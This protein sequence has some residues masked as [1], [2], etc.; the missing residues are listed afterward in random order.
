MELCWPHYSF[1][2]MQVRYRGQSFLA[3]TLHYVTMLHSNMTCLL[4]MADANG[5]R[6]FLILRQ[7][8]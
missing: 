1:H 3:H 4:N 2:E 7:K 8:G 5:F 6:T